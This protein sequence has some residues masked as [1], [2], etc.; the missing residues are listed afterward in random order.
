MAVEK[1]PG[2]LKHVPGHFK[3]E[4][5]CIKAVEKEAETLEHVPDHFKTGEMCKRAIEADLYTLV[6]CPDW[7]VTQEQ[8]KSWY[9]DD[10]DDEATGWYEGYQKRKAQKASIKEELLPIAWHPSRYQ[11]WCV[12][13]DEKKETKK[14]RN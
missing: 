8:I 9:D 7:F 13:E 3:T 10:Y 6:F 5:M 4:K 12:P 2:C 14:L 11:D 1:S